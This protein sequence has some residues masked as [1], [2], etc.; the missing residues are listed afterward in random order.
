MSQ[1]AVS[2]GKVTAADVARLTFEGIAGDRFYIFSHGF[3]P[4][5][6]RVPLED[7]VSGGNPSDP[8]AEKPE[9]GL[10]LRKALAD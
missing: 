2:S 9:L 4:Q 8:F 1:K 10:A 3:A 6:A 5:L 7:L